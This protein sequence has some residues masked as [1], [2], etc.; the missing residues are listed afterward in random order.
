MFVCSRESEAM[1]TKVYLDQENGTLAAPSIKSRQRL[2]SAPGE[3]DQFYTN[4][5]LMKLAFGQGWFNSLYIFVYRASPKNSTEDMAW[6]ACA[7]RPQS[8]GN[9]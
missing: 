7:F 6:S 9:S 3:L 1:D 5:T 4:W 2:Q 8:F